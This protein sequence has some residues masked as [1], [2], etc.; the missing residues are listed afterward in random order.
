MCVVLLFHI[1][2]LPVSAVLIVLRSRINPVYVV[3][4]VYRLAHYQTFIFRVRLNFVLYLDQNHVLLKK[5]QSQN[6][7]L[8]VSIFDDIS[9]IGFIHASVLT[10]HLTGSIRIRKGH[11]N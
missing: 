1:G 4:V 10:L 9:E 3:V 5:R 8:V 11:S 2:G 6:E 7:F